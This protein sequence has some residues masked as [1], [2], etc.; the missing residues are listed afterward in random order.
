MI[1]SIEQPTA[2]RDATLVKVTTVYATGWM[3]NGDTRAR[4][5]T[6][7]LPLGQLSTHYE[8][9][10]AAVPLVLG[11]AEHALRS[12]AGTKRETES[13]LPGRR[14]GATENHRPQHRL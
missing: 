7:S 11:Q 2:A 12:R 1:V 3:V 13:R 6:N 4:P 5:V 10:G 8:L 14:N 9:A